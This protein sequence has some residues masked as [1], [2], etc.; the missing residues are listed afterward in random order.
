MDMRHRRSIGLA[1]V[2]FWS[3][4]AIPGFAEPLLTARL[5]SGYQ[6]VAQ[7]QQDTTQPK[8]GQ[9]AQDEAV[10]KLQAEIDRLKG[11]LS[12]SQADLERERAA[13]KEQQAAGTAQTAEAGRLRQ[14]LETSKTTL[15]T[16]RQNEQ[17]AQQAL[18][19]A[20]Q[21]LQQLTTEAEAM[22]Q[23]LRVSAEKQAQMMGRLKTIYDQ[24]AQHLQDA[25]EQ[26][27]VTVQHEAERL[28]IELRGDAFFAQGQSGLQ[29]KGLPT[30]DKIV[31]FLKP[32]TD[33]QVLVEGHT[34]AVPMSP[35]A[36]K[37]WASNW[38]W[39]AS[40]AAAVARYLET[41]GLPARQL[42][43]TGYGAARPLASND[44]EAGRAQNRRLDIVLQPSSATSKSN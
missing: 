31:A 18:E 14:E 38:E 36:Q 33:Y 15:H 30:L 8:E 40:R 17:Q 39:S 32:L 27:A 13:V 4:M 37:R 22:R 23:R 1:T 42:A 11:D 43:A 35:A 6:Q 12:R 41:K 16:A 3:A 44:T 24:A 9:G 25:V 29:P 10:H 19:G 28:V 34:D 5:A 20:R 21:Q 2:A 26:R 7:Q